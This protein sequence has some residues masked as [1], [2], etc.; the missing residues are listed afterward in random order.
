MPTH[1]R[2]ICSV[3]DKL[4]P[5]LDFEVSE[6]SEPGESG[7]SQGL[8]S[9]HLSDQSSHDATSALEEADS[10]SSRVGSRDVTPD[11]SLSQR[12][13]GKAFKKPKKR[14]RPVELHQSQDAG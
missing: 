9:H 3:I 7:L 14:A 13:D 11:T 8:E 4:P 6:Q 1:L 10:Q 2:S 12:I 5:D